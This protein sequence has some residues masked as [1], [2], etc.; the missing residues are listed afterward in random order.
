VPAAV[1]RRRRNALMARQ[2]RIVA[3]RAAGRVG[4]EVPVLVDGPSAE[5]GLVLQGRIEGQAP[6]IDSIVYL[7]DCDPSIY[8]PGDLVPARIVAA[9]GYDLVAAPIA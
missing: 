5:H 4:T 8:R 6:D 9:R 7:T 1:K 3:A 2:K